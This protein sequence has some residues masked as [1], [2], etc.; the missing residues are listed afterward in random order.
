MKKLSA[1]L[2]ALLL[3]WPHAGLAVVGM[4]AFVADEDQN[5]IPM[6]AAYEVYEPPGGSVH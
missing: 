4:D 2:L 5:F 3:L 1:L 6:P